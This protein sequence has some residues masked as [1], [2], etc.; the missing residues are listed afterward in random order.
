[1]K[2]S[3]AS[4]RMLAVFFELVMLYFVCGISG[5]TVFRIG[6]SSP[7][8][9]GR[10]IGV[11]AGGATTVPPAGFAGSVPGVFAAAGGAACAGG[12]GVAAGAAVLLAMVILTTFSPSFM[13]LR[14]ARSAEL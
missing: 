2:Y 8:P 3:N 1:M 14:T 6:S 10:A 5:G 7:C 11:P 4:S 12:G 13:Y 9:E